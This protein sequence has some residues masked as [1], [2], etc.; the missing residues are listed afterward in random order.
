[1]KESKLIGIIIICLLIFSPNIK[2]KASYP[3]TPSPIETQDRYGDPIIRKIVYKAIKQEPK[4]G[5]KISG[6]PKPTDTIAGKAN[7]TYFIYHV[8]FRDIEY[9]VRAN[10][11]GKIRYIMTSDPRFQTPEGVKEGM[12]FSEVRKLSKGEMERDDYGVYL[13]LASGWSVAFRTKADGELLN[14]AKV[15]W[16]FKEN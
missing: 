13:Q 8:L 12:T 3:K 14:N 10:N 5:A 2:T 16:L 6:Y 4:L 9:G 15:S 7:E 1:M 11:K